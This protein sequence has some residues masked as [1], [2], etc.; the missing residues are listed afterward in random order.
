S[1]GRRLDPEWAVA[2][3]VD[4]CR[5]LEHAHG[6]GIVHRDLKPA[7]VWLAEDGT[8]R[9]GDFGLAA[10]GRRSRDAVEGMLAG[11]V[12]SLPPARALAAASAARADLYSLGALLY[13]MLTGQP[14]FPGDDAVAIISQHLNA[15]P[16]APSVHNPGLPKQADEAILRLLAKSP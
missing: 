5:A 10:T 15:D 8:A 9:L 4:V 6:R 3:G 13:E 12:A 16:V 14:P 7:N 2:V 11:P 1:D